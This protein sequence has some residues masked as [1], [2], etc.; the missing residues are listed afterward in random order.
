MLCIYCKKKLKHSAK[1]VTSYIVNALCNFGFKWL[2]SLRYLYLMVAKLPSNWKLL[3]P[4]CGTELNSLLQ[5][6]L[7]C[8]LV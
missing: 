3:S 7:P 4:N 5:V 2:F 1:N 6:R 8:D